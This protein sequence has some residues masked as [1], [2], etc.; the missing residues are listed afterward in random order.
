MI[1]KM[2]YLYTV[3]FYADTKKNIIMSIAGKWMELKNFMLSEVSQVHKNQ[4]LHV[5]SHMWKLD[6]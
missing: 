5:F 4:R 6:L 1:K 3:E 2:W